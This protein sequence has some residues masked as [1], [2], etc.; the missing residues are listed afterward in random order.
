MKL[1]ARLLFTALLALQLAACVGSGYGGNPWER[2][3]GSRPAQSAPSQL[4]SPASTG[5]RVAASGYEGIMDPRGIKLN[6]EKKAGFEAVF[7]EQQGSAPPEPDLYAQQTPPQFPGQAAV[8]YG[9][10]GAAAPVKVA[11]LVPLS[12]N[13]AQLGEAML[14]AAQM[15]LFDI[16]LENFE[17]MPRD[18]EGTADGARRAAES[19]A[20]DGA[21]L[22]LG[23]LFAAD[24][25]AVKPV[26]RSAGLNVIAF[27]TDWSLA[28]D[29]TFIMGFLPFAQ[30]QRILGYAASHGMARIG[31]FAPDNEY[32][33]AVLSTARSETRRQGLAQMSSDLFP[34]GGRDLGAQVEKFAASGPYDAI[35]LPVGGEQARSVSGFLS[36]AGMEPSQVRRLGTGLMD[37]TALATESGLAGSWFAAPAPRQRAGF[38]SKYAQAY[39]AIPP[40]LA[41][42]AYDATSLAAV[43]A[44]GG[45]QREGRPAFDRAALT[46]P[47]GFA[48]I[49]GIFR[50]RPDGLV[51]R[52]LAVLEYRNGQIVEIDRAPTTFQAAGQM[53]G[54]L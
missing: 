50:F 22:I 52:G 28:D 14:N 16:G 40:R 45:L 47:N 25:R 20:H 37:D 19:A 35:L 31:V 7:P 2:A 11:L 12:G 13:Q 32:G 33:R 51:E 30:V 1:F 10:S 46:N 27:S 29:R 36:L 39:G 41:T 53:A 49:D 6:P 5:N 9:M 43:L 3:G 26:A 4:D 42:L 21:Q 17:L 18:T 38:E 8:P 15:A 24:V 34:P 48:G 44:R 23:P 54:G